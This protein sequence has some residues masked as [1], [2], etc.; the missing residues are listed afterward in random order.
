MPPPA[1][2]LPR[3]LSSQPHS[4]LRRRAGGRARRLRRQPR[5]GRRGGE[6]RS[7]PPGARPCRRRRPPRRRSV[8]VVLNR[9]RVPSPPAPL[10]APA[11]LRPPGGEEGK[12]FGIRG[13]D[14]GRRLRRDALPENTH[15]LDSGCDIH[16]SCLTCPLERCR[17]DEPGG[18]R[19]IFARARDRQIVALVRGHTLTVDAVARRFGVSRRTVFRVLARERAVSPAAHREVS[20]HR[21]RAA[22]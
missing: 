12:T 14:P 6:W 16:P 8:M 9:D 7:T 22:I 3:H 5:P 10:V 21:T 1:R 4:C 13:L 2:A 19:G 18:A 17:Y 11:T 20:R 15:Y